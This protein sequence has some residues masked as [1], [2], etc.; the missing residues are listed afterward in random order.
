MVYKTPPCGPG[1]D[2]RLA[3]FAVNRAPENHPDWRRLYGAELRRSRNGY[4]HGR[5][6]TGFWADDPSVSPE[7]LFQAVEQML[8]DPQTRP[9]KQDRR[10]ASWCGELWGRQVF[11]K[12]YLILTLE[13]QLKY[14]LRVSRAR[15]YWAA[16]RVLT[17]AGFGT[18]R[19]LGYLEIRRGLRPVASFVI[20]RW[21]PLP[22]GRRWLEDSR[23]AGAD[24]RRRFAAALWEQ[25]RRLYA[26]RIYHRDTKLTNLLVDDAL[27]RIAILWTDLECVGLYVS[28]TRHRIIR[29]LVQ[30][31]GSLPPWVPAAE[32]RWFLEL[33]ARDYPALA[34]P[35][36]ARRIHRWTA[37]RLEKERRTGCGP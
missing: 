27:G 6:L 19:A 26:N 7:S 37:R 10:A 16:A 4:H 28:P 23:G 24:K 13:D 29:N 32:R 17:E 25:L 5:R 2:R 15:R 18:P 34:A 1:P 20:S 30:L 9:V 11:L 31:N 33:A 36:A 21:H 3:H 12:R 35:S 22:D 8:A 14:L